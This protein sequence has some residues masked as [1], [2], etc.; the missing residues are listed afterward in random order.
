[1]KLFPNNAL[2]DSK[3][4]TKKSLLQSINYIPTAVFPTCPYSDDPQ[5]YT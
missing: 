2:T 4:V 1:M 3:I 5:E